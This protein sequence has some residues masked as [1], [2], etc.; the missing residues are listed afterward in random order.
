MR[1]YNKKE[2]ILFP[3]FHFLKGE[4]LFENT[5]TYLFL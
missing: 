2:S 1:Y 3:K 5:K 4:I